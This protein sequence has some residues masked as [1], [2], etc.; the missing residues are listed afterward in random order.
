MRKQ[1]TYR[2]KR[3][4]APML[5][6]R[7]LQ[8]DDLEMRERMIAEAFSGGWATE[9]H[10]DELTDMR[11]VLT[12]AAAHKDDQGILGLCHA[13]SIVMNNIRTRYAETQRMGVS[14]DEVKLLREFCGIY[15]DFWLRQSV[16]LYERC[17]DE[18]NLLMERAK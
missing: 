8:N 17:C 18:L 7:G 2:Q 13:M 6:N 16:G 12:I 4:S 5:I 14:G 3:V 10:F 9:R 11:N 15:A 1:S